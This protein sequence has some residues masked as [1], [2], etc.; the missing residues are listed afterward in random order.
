MTPFQRYLSSAHYLPRVYKYKDLAGWKGD[1]RSL[2]I[3][4][5]SVLK[6]F[7][8]SAK[9]PEGQLHRVGFLSELGTEVLCVDSW[10]GEGK[11][12]CCWIS[13]RHLFFE[14][15]HELGLFHSWLLGKGDF[16]ATKPFI[17]PITVH[18]SCGLC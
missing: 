12:R 13:F 18:G 3:D 1:F 16:Q 15:E 14:F 17:R 7:P 2:D 10:S 5:E 9:N 11:S 6:H 8:H 4:I